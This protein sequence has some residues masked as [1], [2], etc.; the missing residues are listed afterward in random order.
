MISTPSPYTEEDLRAYKSLDGYKYLAAGWVGD[1][2][3]HNVIGSVY[4]VVTAKVRHSQTVS[5]PSI[6]PWVAAERNGTILCAHCTCMAGLREACS[7]IAALLFAIE[8]H[9]KVKKDAS[10]TSRP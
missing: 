1:V 6:S 9:T 5:A 2:S 3:T 8:A 4:L 7:H 10:C